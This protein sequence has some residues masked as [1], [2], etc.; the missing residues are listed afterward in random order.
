MKNLPYYQLLNVTILSSSVSGFLCLSIL[1]ASIKSLLLLT[2]ATVISL[3]L[4]R[5]SAATRHMVWV[6]TLIGLL[7]MPA[8]AMLLP[9]WRV[10][11]SWLSLES[12]FE[13]QNTMDNHVVFQSPKSDAPNETPAN[14]ATEYGLFEASETS[15]VPDV[16]IASVSGTKPTTLRLN[17]SSIVGVWGAG[18]GIRPNDTAEQIQQHFANVTSDEVKFKPGDIAPEFEFESETGTMISSKELRGKTIVLHFWATSCGPCMGQMP[19]HVKSL[20][21]LDQS[22]VEVL[23]V[24]LD[25]DKE[26]FMEAVNKFQIPFTNLRDERGWG[27]DLVRAFGVRYMPF[28]IVIGPEGTIVSNSIQDL[29]HLMK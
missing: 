25:D 17:A 23:F 3:A 28:D 19:E 18:V 26:K 7:F 15:T 12:R 11:P 1:D 10:L 21:K 29:K 20:S 22:Q 9:Q 24:S 5:A 8:C 14:P 13:Q 27:S 2:L 6:T 4:V 16:S